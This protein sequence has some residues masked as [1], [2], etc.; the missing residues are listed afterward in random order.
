MSPRSAELLIHRGRA[1]QAQKKFNDAFEDYAAA[2][3]VR[4]E[5][6]SLPADMRAHVYLCRSF[7]LWVW[8]D[9]E[10]A[11]AEA[12]RGLELA[13]GSPRL[14]W[15]RAELLLRL[16]RIDEARKQVEEGLDYFLKK[17]NHSPSKIRA[18]AG[19]MFVRGRA[20]QQLPAFQQREGAEKMLNMFRGAVR[21]ASDNNEYLAVFLVKLWSLGYMQELNEHLGRLDPSRV[22]RLGSLV[23]REGDQWFVSA[24]LA[25]LHLKAGKAQDA[26]EAYGRAIDTDP[27]QVDLLLHCSRVREKLGGTAGAVE[28][29]Q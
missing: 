20:L 26:M 8:E 14:C 1:R 4:D 17:E 15:R 6:E 23:A 28:D 21:Y 13:P 19:L 18:Y 10:A 16:G 12:D 29:L 27:G 24:L 5:F 22:L 2:V 9:D 25:R 7:I 11:L 3:A